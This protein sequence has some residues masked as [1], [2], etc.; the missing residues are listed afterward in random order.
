MRKSGLDRAWGG[1]KSPGRCGGE[2][3]NP[4][5]LI[6]SFPSYILDGIY[7]TAPSGERLQKVAYWVAVRARAR[8]L[9]PEAIPGRDYALTEVVHCKSED[10]IGV[11]SASAECTSKHPASFARGPQ[12][13]AG[14]YADDLL[15]LQDAATLART[16]PTVARY[17]TDPSLS[18]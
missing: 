16:T 15:R 4:E 18:I 14:L 7:T 5:S 17:L 11:F 8:E 3:S 13:L 10:E 9:I 1:R 6:V 12:T 2:P